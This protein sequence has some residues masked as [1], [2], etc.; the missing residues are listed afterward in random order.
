MGRH[1]I[2]SELESN[3]NVEKKPK[4][5]W[6]KII[7]VIIL[8]FTVIIGYFVYTDLKQEELLKT[9]IQ[10]YIS[11]DFTKDDFT[12]DIKTT[13]DYA[14]VEAAIKTYFKGL[15][16][17]AKDV[18]KQEN[19]QEFINILTIENF[20][21]DGPNFIVTLKKISDVRSSFE[22]NIN[23]FV[24]MCSEEYILS[25]ITKYD[26]LDSYYIDLYKELMFAKVDLK[27][28][29]NI[30]KEMIELKDTF[31]IFLDDCYNMIIFLK[32]NKGKWLIEEDS[33]VFDSDE[34]LKEYN[35]LTQK[36][37]ENNEV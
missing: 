34:L 23:K 8:L 10:E 15:S 14:L 1:V 4:R 12:V 22:E 17:I 27:S 20:K 36:L 7:I 24:N 28:I 16:D 37:L 2:G 6:L 33:I 9:E 29:E 18:E 19:D 13:G 32:N 3:T 11:R 25:L 5:I 21:N 35:N 30:K 26:E 31:S